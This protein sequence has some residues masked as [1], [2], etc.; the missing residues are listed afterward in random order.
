MKRLLTGLILLFFVYCTTEAQ[1]K[2]LLLNGDEITTGWLKFDK[3][4]SLY[5]YKNLKGKYR[6]VEPEFIFSISDGNHE[7]KVLYQPDSILN[8]Q[9]DEMYALIMGQ[10]AGKIHFKPYIAFSTG[11]LNGMGGTL[12]PYKLGINMFYSTIIPFSLMQT[13][14]LFPLN[15]KKIQV[16]AGMYSE[17]YLK[18]YK[19]KAKKKRFIYHFLGTLSGVAVSYVWYALQYR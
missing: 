13:S 2:L 18:G 5:Y 7:S 12:I 1:Y 9:P 11:F 6:F 17:Y 15:T 4:D 8:Y 3:V 10:K 14:Y 19:I 16:P